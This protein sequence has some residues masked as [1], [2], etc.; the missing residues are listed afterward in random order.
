MLF[1][2]K[3]RPELDKVTGGWRKAD[4]EDIYDL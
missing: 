3:V 4:I 1:R 2:R